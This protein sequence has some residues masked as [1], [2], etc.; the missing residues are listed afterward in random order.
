MLLYT[1]G[2]LLLFQQST[3]P[4]KPH[5]PTCVPQLLHSLNGKTN[6]QVC[7]SRLWGYIRTYPL[8][9]CKTTLQNHFPQ[10]LL[11]PCNK[12]DNQCTF[13]F[14]CCYGRNFPFVIFVLQPIHCPQ[15]SKGKFYRLQFLPYC[16]FFPHLAS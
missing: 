6:C 10:L 8:S 4:K 1:W 14:V 15:K 2:R 5:Y 11:F 3:C 7:F 9:E 13:L 16:R 12:K